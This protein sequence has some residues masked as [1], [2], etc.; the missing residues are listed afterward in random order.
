MIQA[1]N[2]LLDRTF[3][4]IGREAFSFQPVARASHLLQLSAAV[5]EAGA[6]R[7]GKWDD[8]LATEVIVFD[9]VSTG[10]AAIPHQIGYPMK[11]VS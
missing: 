9:E 11:T 6:G 2:P 10:Q 8:R 3:R 4:H 5:A 7:R 1:L